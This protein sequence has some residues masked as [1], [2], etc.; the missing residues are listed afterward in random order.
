MK[1]YLGSDRRKRRGKIELISEVYIL[2]KDIR[3]RPYIL[4]LNDK[5]IVVDHMN[6]AYL[7]KYLF[8]FF[9]V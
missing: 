5:K 9:L 6:Q 2:S 7:V 4:F 8:Y 1:H 3:L